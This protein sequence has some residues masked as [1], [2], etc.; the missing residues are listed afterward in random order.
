MSRLNKTDL[1]LLYTGQNIDLSKPEYA[2]LGG[3][4]MIMLKF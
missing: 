4:V 2:Y 1:E 3:M